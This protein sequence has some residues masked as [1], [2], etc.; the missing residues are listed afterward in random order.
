M[1][2]YLSQTYAK[3]LQPCKQIYSLDSVGRYQKIAETL[4]VNQTTDVGYM[5]QLNQARA[6]ESFGRNEVLKFRE[7]FCR[8]GIGV[9]RSR[10]CPTLHIGLVGLNSFHT[11]APDVSVLLDELGEKAARWK[12]AGHVNLY[13]HLSR[14][15]IAGTNAD[16]GDLQLLRDQTGYL[17]RYCFEDDSEASGRLYGLG[18]FEDFEGAKRGFSLDSE[19][20]KGVLALGCKTDVAKDWDACSCD[21]LYCW[22]H[23]QAT[24]ELDALDPTFFDHSDC[25]FKGLLGGY[26]V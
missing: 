2:R 12:V 10:I 17:S 20:A 22:G 21:T 26:L 7:L 18:I 15:T 5:V 25:G 14:A 8:H 16:S 1:Q 11:L 13:Q 24:F 19:A 9:L 4:R 23:V 6:S 3:G